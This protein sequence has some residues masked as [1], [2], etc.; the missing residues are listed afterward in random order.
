MRE[1]FKTRAKLREFVNI[2]PGDQNAQVLFEQ[3]Y[4]PMFH[5]CEPQDYYVQAAKFRQAWTVKEPE[6]R[7]QVSRNLEEIFAQERPLGWGTLAMNMVQVN[8][9]DH[10]YP[11][12]IRP[13][14]MLDELAFTLLV[15]AD[16]LGIC[17]NPECPA[18][19]FV[20][21]HHKQR[22]CS[23]DCADTSRKQAKLEWWRENRQGQ[24]KPQRRKK[25]RKTQ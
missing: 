2:A 10:E 15:S 4:G 1:L 13:R 6:D 17:E 11:I 20:A 25:G 12:E 19:Y 5:G 24:A 21:A 14:N 22:Y 9:G 23:Y 8:F 7:E 16:S 3:R 18:K